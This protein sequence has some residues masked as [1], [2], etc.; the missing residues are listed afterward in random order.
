MKFEKVAVFIK[1]SDHF[2]H[3]FNIGH[4]FSCP[5]I[6]YKNLKIRFISKFNHGF[7]NHGFNNHLHGAIL[8]VLCNFNVKRAYDA[9]DIQFLYQNVQNRFLNFQNGQ[10]Q[11]LN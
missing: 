5:V 9:R 10:K 6:L 1:I 7:T 4:F 3:K 8:K 11:Q 2:H